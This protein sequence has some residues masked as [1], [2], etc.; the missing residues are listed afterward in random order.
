MKDPLTGKINPITS[1]NPM[2]G[3]AM[4]RLIGT[5]LAMS[6]IPLWIN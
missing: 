3:L 6:A 1:K 4:K 5:T 2:K